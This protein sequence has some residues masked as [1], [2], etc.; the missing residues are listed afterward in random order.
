M[1]VPGALGAQLG[2]ESERVDVLA[3]DPAAL[4]DALGGLELVR[5]VDVPGLGPDCGAVRPGVGAQAHP[6]HRLDPAGNADVDGPDRDQAGDQ[7]VGLLAAAALAVDSG[8]ADMIGKAGGQPRH[9]AD[10]VGLLPELRHAT[11]DDL[12]DIS[13]L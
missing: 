13:G 3:G 10:V 7:M 2:F 9:S 6:A 11:A 1:F 8:G 12:F 5:H 4:G